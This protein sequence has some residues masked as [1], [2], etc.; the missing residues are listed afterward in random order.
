MQMLCT[1]RYLILCKCSA[2]AVIKM[3]RCIW[4]RAGS[5][6]G[7]FFSSL[8]TRNGD[9]YENDAIVHTD[10]A[11]LPIIAWTSVVSANLRKINSAKLVSSRTGLSLSNPRQVSCSIFFHCSTSDSDPTSR[12]TND[13]SL[14]VHHSEIPGEPGPV[15]VIY[16][17][18]SMKLP[19]YY[20]FMSSTDFDK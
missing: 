14:G 2:Q 18:I 13:Y 16:W 9:Y 10:L 3:R 4:H 19:D 1:C 11:S 15:S 5:C 12:S 7:W 6:A 20:I 8:A 17:A